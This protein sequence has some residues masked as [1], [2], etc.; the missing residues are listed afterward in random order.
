LTGPDPPASTCPTCR[1]P[2][3][4]AR[5]AIRAG[6]CPLCGGGPYVVPLHH[7]AMRHGIGRRAARKLFGLGSTE[8]ACDPDHSE[9]HRALALAYGL[10]AHRNGSKAR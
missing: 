7:V 2:V 10:G 9:L 3:I 4:P 5:E 1:R 8:P 6:L